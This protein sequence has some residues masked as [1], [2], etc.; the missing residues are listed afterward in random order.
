MNFPWDFL[1]FSI[2]SR[3]FLIL[4]NIKYHHSEDSF[5]QGPRSAHEDSFERAWTNSASSF[6]LE[7]IG[8]LRAPAAS[9]APFL[10]LGIIEI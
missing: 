7:S 2:I 5:S 9:P 6:N 4:K 1:G 10:C 8:T 3:W